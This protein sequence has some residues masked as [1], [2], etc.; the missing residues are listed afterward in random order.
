MYFSFEESPEQIMRN[1]RSIGFNLASW[2]KQ[3]LLEF[4]SIRPQL[5]GLEMHLANIHKLVKIFKPDGV[6]M[7]PITNLTSVGDTA[8]IKAMLTRV[9]DFLKNQGITSIY[10]SLTAGGSFLEQSEAGISSL[11]DTW[12]LVRTVESDN[13]RNRLLYILK[14][15]GMAHSNQMREFQLSDDGIKLVDVYVGP[16]IALTG[17]ARLIQEAKDKKQSAV[18]QENAERRRCEL[19][20]EQAALQ[21]Q[22]EAL[23]T[24]LGN[25]RNELKM[26]NQLDTERQEQIR[27][28]RQELAM[29]RKADE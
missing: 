28:E 15:R 23:K 12:L 13:E 16:G 17:T 18:D 26:A 9:I 27:K 10:T 4:Y 24:K 6:V 19:Q 22:I 11:I 1:M 29:A 3:G 7:D 20:Q 14:S 5:Y 21:V 2:V 8:E 25:I